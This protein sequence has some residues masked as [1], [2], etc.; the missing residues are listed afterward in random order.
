MSVEQF[1]L[2]SE[3]RNKAIREQETLAAAAVHNEEI[4]RKRVENLETHAEGVSALLG[5]GL[6]GR[7]TWLLFGR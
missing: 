4:T 6:W 7:L 1:S 5:R 3:R 2:K